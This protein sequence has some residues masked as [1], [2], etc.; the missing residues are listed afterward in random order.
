MKENDSS[1]KLHL[2]VNVKVEYALALGRGKRLIW[3][4]GRG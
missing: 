3:G 1:I 2:K 4:E